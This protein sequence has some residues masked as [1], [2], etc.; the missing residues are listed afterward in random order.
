MRPKKSTCARLLKRLEDLTTAECHD[1]AEV[2]SRWA[3]SEEH[4]R[5]I[6]IALPPRP[7]AIDI[8][9]TAA[10]V[11]PPGPVRRPHQGCPKCFGSGFAVAIGPHGYSGARPC[12]CVT[13]QPE[14]LLR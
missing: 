11:R 12:S 6:V 10:Q 7:T 13:E 2:L 5:R 3:H 1:L 14:L 9:K 4:A 8:R